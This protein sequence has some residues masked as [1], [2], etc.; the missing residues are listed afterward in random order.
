VAADSQKKNP[1]KNLF[2]IMDEIISQLNKTKKM[3][4]FMILTLMILPPIS[5]VITFTVLGPPMFSDGGVQHRE[6]FGIG[7]GRGFALARVVPILI[8]VVWLG[9]G[10]RQWLVL[11]KWTKKYERYKE[12]QKKIDEKLDYEE[13]FDEGKPEKQ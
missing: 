1:D 3:F 13:N 9:I 8:F 5:F 4:I 2:Q 11:S 6:G 10:I 12:L 7:F